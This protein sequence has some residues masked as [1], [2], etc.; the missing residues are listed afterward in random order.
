ML[1][2]PKIYADTDIPTISIAHKTITNVLSINSPFC[3]SFYFFTV[4]W[5]KNCSFVQIILAKRKTGKHARFADQK[6]A[7]RKAK[8]NKK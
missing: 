8:T 6:A 4:E 2:W 3:D 5:F 1:V 7:R